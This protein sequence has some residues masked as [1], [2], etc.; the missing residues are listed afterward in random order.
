MTDNNFTI[1]DF[2]TKKQEIAGDMKILF[3]EL[4]TLRDWMIQHP[5]DDV[6]MDTAKE[7]EDGFYGLIENFLFVGHDF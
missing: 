3:N 5:V 4:N 2:N 1:E 6:T 7:W